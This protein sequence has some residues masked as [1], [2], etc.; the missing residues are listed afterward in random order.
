M[1]ANINFKFAF[2]N[3]Q[4]LDAVIA[5]LKS[6]A[7]YSARVAGDVGYLA[8]SGRF[9]AANLPPG[10]RLMQNGAVQDLRTGQILG[11]TRSP[12]QMNVNKAAGFAGGTLGAFGMMGAGAYIG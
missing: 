12:L 2:Q 3:T 5:K 1:S 9:D 8:R 7:D 6:A 11:S 4:A 10:T